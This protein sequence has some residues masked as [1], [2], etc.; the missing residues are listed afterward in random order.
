MVVP[1]TQVKNRKMLLS[2][3]YLLAVAGG[4][5]LNRQ[6]RDGRVDRVHVLAI[7]MTDYETTRVTCPIVPTH[8]EAMVLEAGLPVTPERAVQLKHSQGEIFKSKSSCSVTWCKLVD[9]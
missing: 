5:M 6:T 8:M 3:L 4:L 7:A 2:K 1:F 9:N